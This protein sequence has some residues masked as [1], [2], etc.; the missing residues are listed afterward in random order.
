MEAEEESQGGAYVI[1]HD[2]DV[3]DRYKPDRVWLGF[4]IPFPYPA[5]DI[6][7]HF[8]DPGLARRRRFARRGLQ[9]TTWRDGPA[10]Q[11]SRRSN[12]WNPATDT[13]AGKL[14]KV[15]EWMRMP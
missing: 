12:R 10:L 3:G 15:L 11:V 5:A 13:A 6:Y 14:L 2:L 4:L 1:V 7:P 8:T 9:P